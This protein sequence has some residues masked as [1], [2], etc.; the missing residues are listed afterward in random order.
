MESHKDASEI[1]EFYK[2]KH[3]L[4]T[5]GTGMLGKLLFHRLKKEDPIFMERLKIVPGDVS[6][7]GHGLSSADVE[8]LIEKVQ[9]VFHTAAT[10]KFDEPLSTATKINSVVHVSTAYSH[11]PR[12]EIREEF[13]QTPIS[14][15]GLIALDDNLSPQLLN[16][17]TPQIMGEWINTYV[18]TKAVAEEA[19][20]ENV[21]TTRSE[22]IPNWIAHIHGPIII[23]V[24]YYVGAACVLKF[25]NNDKGELV[26]ADMTVNCLL[27]VGYETAKSRFLKKYN[28]IHYSMHLLEY[29]TTQTWIFSLE[30][31]MGLWRSLNDEDKKLFDFNMESLDF[32]SF[33]KGTIDGIRIYLKDEEKDLTCTKR[34]YFIPVFTYGSE[35]WDNSSAEEKEILEQ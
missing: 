16:V 27:A 34:R 30:N 18:F 29:F 24:G 10:V 19:V 28:K 31:T 14:P 23:L 5:G 1:C 4:L 25:N 3:V 6:E 12:K 2:D 11:S 33:L 20:R 26:P 8:H 22:P 32:K 21:L 9:V 13:Y 17:I 35:T 7:P 15:Q